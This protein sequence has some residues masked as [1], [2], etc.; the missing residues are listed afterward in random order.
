MQSGI[1]RF[2]W[3]ATILLLISLPLRFGNQIAALGGEIDASQLGHL[4]F[5]TGWGAGLWIHLTVVAMGGIGLALA[6]P[7]G[8]GERGWGIFAGAAVLIPLV[9]V[10]QGHAWGVE[11][12]RPLAATSLY[13]HVAG[14]GLWLGGLMLLVAVG[15]PAVRATPPPPEE[16]EDE[17]TVLPALAQLVNAFSRLALLS[18]SL[19]LL[20]GAINAWINVGSVGNLIGSPYGRTLLLKLGVVAG[21][22]LLGFYNWRKV[23]PGLA[24]RPDPG[25]LR[26]P[27]TV[28]AALGLG[29]LLATAFLVSTPTP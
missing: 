21:A 25:A 20:T 8:L 29:V 16:L 2:G 28:E 18:V 6:S 3:V 9:S 27:A 12:G 10:L 7:R 24:E 17:A 15:L 14:S 23:R 13:F 19:V 26:I 4:L 22:L 5:Q 1:W 11:E